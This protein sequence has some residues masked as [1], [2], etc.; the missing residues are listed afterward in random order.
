[1]SAKAVRHL[2]IHR[3][4]GCIVYRGVAVHAPCLMNNKVCRT[5]GEREGSQA[6]R[7]RDQDRRLGR[8]VPTDG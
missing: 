1:M 4:D 5:D 2:V 3:L 8:R 7:A 6:F